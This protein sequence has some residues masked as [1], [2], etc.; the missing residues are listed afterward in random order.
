MDSTKRD[1]DAIDDEEILRELVSI[2]KRKKR[3]DGTK[4][5]VTPDDGDTSSTVSDVAKRVSEVIEKVVEKEP[6]ETTPGRSGVEVPAPSFPAPPTVATS[7]TCPPLPPTPY[8]PAPYP[9]TNTYGGSPGQ[10]S[11]SYDINCN[12]Y[13]GGLDETVTDRDLI[14]LFGRYG[15]VREVR[16]PYYGNKFF[17]HITYDN[18]QSV[19]DA[20]Q[21]QDRFYLGHKPLIVNFAKRSKKKQKKEK[22]KGK[23]QPRDRIWVSSTHPRGTPVRLYVRGIN[24]DMNAKDLAAVLGPSVCYVELEYHPKGHTGNGTVSFFTHD[25]AMYFYQNMQNYAAGSR[26]LTF[27]W[28]G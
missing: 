20:M 28:I 8:P 18:P 12:L 15:Y 17:C 1:R 3:L 13:V 25:D 11:P 14:D 19:L 26:Y 10:L 16:W 9:S 2:L 6:K 22:Q 24:W 23:T 27:E 4:A 7:S 21:Y 5:S